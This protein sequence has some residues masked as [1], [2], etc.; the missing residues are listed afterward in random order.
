ML[1]SEPNITPH[2]EIGVALYAS[3]TRKAHQ[4]SLLSLQAAPK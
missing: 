1:Q 4:S 3:E 2:F